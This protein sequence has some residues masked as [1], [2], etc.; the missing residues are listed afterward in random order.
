MLRTTWAD[1][2]AN[3]RQ[4]IY[5]NQWTL[6]EFTD[7]DR[8]VVKATRFP[9]VDGYADVE[10]DLYLVMPSEPVLNPEAAQ[11]HRLVIPDIRP[12]GIETRFVR[13]DPA[14]P[15]G[16]NEFGYTGPLWVSAYVLDSRWSTVAHTMLQTFAHIPIGMEVRYRRGPSS[17]DFG[18]RIGK[19]WERPA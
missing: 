12:D 1:K 17:F 15:N 14:A 4:R 8:G 13:F 18:N 7:P 19:V 9:T 2:N 6:L 5:R 3:T 10:L 11:Q 16:R